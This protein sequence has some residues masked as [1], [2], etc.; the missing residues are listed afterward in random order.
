MDIHSLAKILLY[1]HAALGGISLLAGFMAALVNKFGVY[2]KPAGK[3]F[4][5][6]LLYSSIIAIILTCLPGHHNQ[7]FLCIA[8]FSLYQIITGRRAIQYKR[9]QKY[10]RFDQGLAYVLFLTALSMIAIGFVEKEGL[11][12]LLWVFGT[13]CAYLS[14]EDTIRHRHPQNRVK[15]WMTV[16]I[17]QMGGGFIASVTAFIV[18]NGIFPGIWGWF[19]PGIIG[20]FFIARAQRKYV[21]KTKLAN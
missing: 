15:N 20:G 10:Q 13:F 18:V 21:V 9:N 6:S 14:I 12:V 5:F 3:I 19:L 4:Y 16:H 8:I 2:H 11:R 7:F 1:F 17:N